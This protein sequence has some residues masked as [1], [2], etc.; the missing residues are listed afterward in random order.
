MNT[1]SD[2]LNREVPARTASGWVMLVITILLLAAGLYLISHPIVMLQRGAPFAFKQI[3]AGLI[4]EFAFVLLLPGF[5]TLTPNQAA[6]LI[7]FGA[8]Q[9]TERHS[10]FH[11]TNPFNRKLRISLRARNLNGDKLKVNDKRGNPI[12][13][14]AVVVWRV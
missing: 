13:M 11:W 10:G 5:F 9:G 4:C 12:E 14:A 2:T 1:S 6:V 8:Y 7:L 3:I